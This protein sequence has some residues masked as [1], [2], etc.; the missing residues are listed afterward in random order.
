MRAAARTACL[1]INLEP[2]HNTLD[3]VVAET[4]CSLLAPSIAR[5][6]PKRGSAFSYLLGVATNAARA[7]RRRVSACPPGVSARNEIEDDPRTARD[8][9][10]HRQWLARRITAVMPVDLR[11]TV[12]RHVCDDEP[13]LRIA[14]QLGVD[15]TTLHRRIQRAF[16]AIRGSFEL[17]A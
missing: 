5:F 4:Y 16:A 7:T 10:E 13:L 12:C 1:R 2:Q 17:A 14:Q 11:E 9:T 8:Q 3:D 15:R 6:D